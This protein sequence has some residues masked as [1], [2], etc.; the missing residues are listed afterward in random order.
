MKRLTALLLVLAVL[1]MLAGCDAREMAKKV[2]DTIKAISA[3]SEFI[4]EGVEKIE[5]S[6]GTINGNIYENKYMGYTFEKP[7]S[8]VYATDKEIAESLEIGVEN[9][10]K[11]DFKNI[12]E[13]NVSIYDMMVVDES[14]GTNICIGYENLALLSQTDIT[15]EQYME[16]LRQQFSS[17]TTMTVEFDRKT[18]K[19]KLGDVEF[20]RAICVLQ[21][22]GT[23]LQ[24]IYYIHKIDN[25]MGFAIVTI[26]DGYDMFE[27]EG[28]F[29]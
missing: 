25:Y 24:Q 20:T 5:I 28:M 10:V 22:G 19:V 21:T 9:F 14:T 1:V 6:R 23:Y 27:I 26:V 13:N 7:D 11:E 12:A 15:E 8:W 2:A 29:N 16:A 17:V 3:M 4:G 18:T